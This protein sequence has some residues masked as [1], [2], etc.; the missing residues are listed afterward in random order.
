MPSVFVG[1]FYVQPNVAQPRGQAESYQGVSTN[2]K[3]GILTER[4]VASTYK[5]RPQKM[6][7]LSAY[8]VP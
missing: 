7:F 1:W 6:A 4:S 2:L 5:E 3:T 8:V